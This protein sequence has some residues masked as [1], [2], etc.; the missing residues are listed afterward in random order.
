MPELAYL[1]GKIMPIS[2]AMVPAEDRGYNFGDA[3]YEFVASYNGRLFCLEEHLDRLERSMRELALV[4]LPRETVRAAILDFFTQAAI[5]RAGIYLQISR[6]VAPRDHAYPPPGTPLQFF[7]TIR[8]VHEKPAELRQKG[9][10]AITVTDL[11]WGRCDIK[12][13]QLLPNCMAKQQAL[14]AGAFDA[15]FVS[16]DGVVREGTSSNLFI[17]KSGRLITHPLTEQILPG[18]TRQVVMG[19]CREERIVVEERFY[20]REELAAADEVFLTGTITEVLPITRIDGK[21][22]GD[23]AVGHLSHRLYQRLLSRIQD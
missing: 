22:V 20:D 13:V 23:G 3:V 19:I 1:N 17:A 15:I 14:A 21:A 6:G 9:A 18:I 5:P 4:G 11:R 8:P 16:A 2:D 7:M 10:S 12:T